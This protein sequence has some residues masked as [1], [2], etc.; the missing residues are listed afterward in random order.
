MNIVQKKVED[1]VVGNFVDLESCPYLKPHPLAKKAFA[2]VDFIERETDSCIV[3]GYEGIDRVGYPVGTVLSVKVPRDVPDPA[4]KVRPIGQPEEWVEW[5]ISQNLTDRWGDINYYNAENKPLEVLEDDAIRLER[6]LGQ[7]WDEITFIVRK[8]GKFGIL[9]EVEYVSKESEATN[10]RADDPEYLALKPHEE[11][12]S[13]L[14]NGLQQLKPSYPDVQFAIP[15]ESQ[16]IDDRPAVW[17]FV[18]D[19]LLSAE[20]R[21]ELGLAL[22]SL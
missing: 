4:I 18:A 20:Q 14:K 2:E 5:R 19:G 8:D 9:F 17:A 1:L 21:A 16:V 3:I 12:I 6:L 13:I 15:E 22:L 7:M 11:I 10:Y